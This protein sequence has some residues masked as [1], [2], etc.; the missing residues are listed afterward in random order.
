MDNFIISRIFDAPRSL[1]FDCWVNPERFEKW[2]MAPAGCTCRIIHADVRPGGYYHLLQTSPDGT[3]VYCKFEFKEINPIEH[4]VLVTQL[5]DENMTTIQNPFAADWPRRLL[6]KITFEDDGARTKVTVYWDPIDP[7]DAEL[8][9]F[10][11]N[12]HNGQQGWRESFD[13]LERTI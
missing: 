8:T 5:C 10:V 13:Q 9:F 1:V 2:G 3:E 7:T 11:K 4:L 12:I 6:A